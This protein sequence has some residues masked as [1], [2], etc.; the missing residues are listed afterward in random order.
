MPQRILVVDDEAHILQVLSLKLRN[1]GYEVL[2]AVDGEEALEY[3]TRQTIDVV[4][5]DY[6]MPYMTGLDLCRALARNPATANVPV[7]LLT[8][9]GHTLDPEDL[10]LRNIRDVLSKPFSPRAVVDL[11]QRLLDGAA[12][13]ASPRVRS[14]VA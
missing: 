9:R 12:G 11:V 5:S 13:G 10:T 6:Q 14:E 8:A 7:L 1:A 4:I 2:T 3:A